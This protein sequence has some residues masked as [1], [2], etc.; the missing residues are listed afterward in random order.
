[1]IALSSLRQRPRLF[2]WMHRLGL[3]QAQSQTHPEEREML[4]RHAAIARSAVEVGTFMGL[5]AGCL[6]RALPDDGVLYCVDPY[7]GGGESI[8][9]VAHRHLKRLGVWKHIRMLRSDSHG[10]M[11]S[12]PA[13]VDFFFVDGDHSYDGLK[14]DWWVVRQLLRPGGIAA[15]HDTA[16]DPDASLHSEGAIR[17]FEE[18]IAQDAEFEI[19]DRVRSLNLIRR[20]A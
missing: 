7:P 1:M 19:V 15:F 4:C 2:N 6:A 13:R 17:F 18:V 11:A 3:V 10:A 5:T 12:L 14:A 8:Q 20:K 9:A 16:R